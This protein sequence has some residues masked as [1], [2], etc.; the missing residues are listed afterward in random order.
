MLVLADNDVL[1]LVARLRMIL[2]SDE[3]AELLALVDAQF[4]DFARLGLDLSASDREVWTTCQ[5]VGAVLITAN[6]AG[7]QNSLNQVIRESLGLSIIP[8]LT[9]A[10]PQRVIRDSDYAQLVALR[11]LDYLDRIDSLRG[12]GRLFLP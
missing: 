10:D 11:L 4:T 2:E 7:G 5:A 1:G 9:L 3:W 8:V 6:R 12:T